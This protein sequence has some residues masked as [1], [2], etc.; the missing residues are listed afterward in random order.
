[1]GWHVFVGGAWEESHTPHVLVGGEW[2]QVIKG[3]VFDTGAWHRFFPDEE[4]SATTIV[5]GLSGSVYVGT[6]LT[7]WGEV[8]VA[9]GVVPGGT[10]QLEQRLDGEG[11][12]AWVIVGSTTI[13]DPGNPVGNWSMTATPQKCGASEFRA[14]YSGS[15][16]VQPS[17]SAVAT[18]VVQIATPAQMSGGTITN[19]SLAV[20][21][22]AVPGATG[23]RLY[24]DGSPVAD[25]GSG[26]TSY[27]Y[28]GLSPG[29]EYN[30]TV[31]ALSG[32]CVSAQ[33][34]V[35]QGRTSADQVIDSGSATI[36]VE[37]WKTG[38]YRPDEAWGYIGEKV[39]Q[40]YYTV[41]TRNYTGCVDFGTLAMMQGKVVAAL[42]ANGDQRLANGTI[43]G[44]RLYLHKVS[45]VGVS[46]SVTV[47]FYRSASECDVGG[48]PARLGTK[49]DVAS[50][51]NG[52]AKWYDIGVAHADA[53]VRGTG[54]ARSIVLY[55][56]GTPN[57]AQFQARAYSADSCDM[58]MD[59]SWNYEL[60]PAV[61]GAW[62][63]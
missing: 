25:V 54:G 39:G 43:T 8:T 52:A 20:S 51:V 22:S 6:G 35:K 59:W 56:F 63:N 31:S 28:A 55:D 26:T 18:A 47:S 40:G 58:Q 46:G 12:G 30:L 41:S 10:V 2:R 53:I 1:M 62:L 23:Y 17:E 19:T 34:P 33:S 45:G 42:G 7:V 29:T 5:G 16:G 4:P 27:E 15:G 61:A 9:E 38:S 44:A 49:V 57:Y 37:A 50:T 60:T 3:Y 36:Q 21:W 24:R 14:V 11:D 32:A 48:E 13:A